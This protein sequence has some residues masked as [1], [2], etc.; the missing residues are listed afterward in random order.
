LGRLLLIEAMSRVLSVAESSGCVGLIADAKDSEAANFYA[1]FGFQPAPESPLLLFM[2]F[3]EIQELFRVGAYSTPP[4][5][6]S[7]TRGEF[8]N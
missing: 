8:I 2:P 3:P 5:L 7:I 6:L 1:A 4:P